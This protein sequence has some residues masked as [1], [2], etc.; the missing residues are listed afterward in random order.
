MEER[1]LSG[2]RLA[3]WAFAVLLLVAAIPA[4]ASHDTEEPETLRLHL[5]TDQRAFIYSVGPVVQHISNPKCAVSIT[6]P[7]AAVSGSD[8]GPGMFGPSIGVRT[9]RA[10]GVPCARVDAT[11][12]LT[13]SLIG[14]P[15]ADAVDLDLELKG[16]AKVKIE[17]FSGGAL[18]GSYE[19]RSGSSVVEGEGTDS[20]EGV[21]FMV[22]VTD[23]APIGNC[24]NSSDSGPDSGANDN[25]YVS[26]R[27]TSTFDAI[28][29]SPLVG[30]M[31]LEGSADFAGNPEF[32]TI[33]YLSSFDG[34]LGCDPENN[35]APFEEDAVTG[36]FTRFENSDGSECVEKPFNLDVEFGEGDEVVSFVPVDVGEPQPSTYQ[37]ELTYSPDPA[38]NPFTNFLEYDQDDDDIDEFEPVPWC[39]GD[40]FADPDAPGSINTGVIPEGDTWCIVS[41][42]TEVFDED[43]IVTTW[44]VVGKGDPKLRG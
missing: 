12:D 3:A 11:E 19:I 6:G 29:F 16:S 15:V 14:V 27:P 23:E 10:S 8:G 26:I 22:T 35:T 28:K 41:A 24:N 25:C 34:M 13:V 37:G 33:F 9:G 32:D 40:P 21:P 1:N 31:S 30:E 39:D 20:T 7:L 17:I 18:V 38:S 43:E 5:A 4:I 2:R 42:L 44:T 36:T